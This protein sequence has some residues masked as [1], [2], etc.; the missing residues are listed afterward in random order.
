MPGMN[1]IRRDL[2]LVGEEP[3]E[4]SPVR[5]LPGMKDMRLRELALPGDGGAWGLGSPSLSLAT[6]T[7]TKDMRGWQL[8]AAPSAALRVGMK[9]IRR[10]GSFAKSFSVFFAEEV[11]AEVSAAKLAIL[12]MAPVHLHTRSVVAS[13]A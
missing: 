7:G 10:P 2:P 13:I 12:E 3:S 8:S 6:R 5:R 11:A 1:D 9:D 4:M